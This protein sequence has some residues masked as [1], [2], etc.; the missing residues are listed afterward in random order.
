MPAQPSVGDL[1]RA[2]IQGSRIAYVDHDPFV[3]AHV[4]RCWPAA[5]SRP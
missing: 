4:E 5:A 1:A 3:T 2:V